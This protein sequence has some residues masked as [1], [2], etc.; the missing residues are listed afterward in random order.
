MI[1]IFYI[2][3]NL[4]GRLSKNRCKVRSIMVW[5]GA[6][7]SLFQIGSASK[8]G[9]PSNSTSQYFI[10]SPVTVRKH[11]SLINQTLRKMQITRKISRSNIFLIG[12]HSMQGWTTT[13]SHGVARK[14][15]T[16]KIKAGKKSVQKES[17]VKRCLLIVDLKLLRSKVKEKHSICR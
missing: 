14:R 1:N 8:L 9:S 17:T 11:L 4:T 12:T 15:S 16:K 7:G 2:S 10:S 13:A 6:W 5:G 3:A